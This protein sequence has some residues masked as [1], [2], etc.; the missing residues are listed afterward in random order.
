MVSTS[1]AAYGNG[2]GLVG[3]I[4]SIAKVLKECSR[5]WVKMQEYGLMLKKVGVYGCNS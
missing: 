5:V 3:L 2:V 1:C 4:V